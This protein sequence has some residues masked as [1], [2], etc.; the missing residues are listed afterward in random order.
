MLAMEAVGL[1]ASAFQRMA[2]GGAR[3][4]ST[5]HKRSATSYAFA[6]AYGVLLRLATVSN[7]VA[8]VIIT[9]A[10]IALAPLALLAALLVSPFL[11]IAYVGWRA[12]RSLMARWRLPAHPRHLWHAL[13]AGLPA[14][15]RRIARKP[16]GD[17]LTT[18]RRHLI[19]LI[20]KRRDVTLW[21]IPAA[22]WPEVVDLKAPFVLCVP[23]LVTRE[24]P[25]RFV[26][27]STAIEADTNETLKT[28]ERCTN[29]ITY[30]Q[31]VKSSIANYVDPEKST[32]R[33]IPNGPNELASQIRVMNAPLRSPAV[34]KFANQV[35][36]D[37]RNI[38]LQANPYLRTFDFDTIRYVFY[39]AQARPNKNFFTLIRAYRDLL[40]KSMLPHKLIVTADLRHLPDVWSY[41]TEQRLQYDVLM[42]QRVSDQVLAALYYK[43]ELAVCP[44]LYEGGFPFTFCEALSVGTPAVLAR[45]P[46]VL[47]TL[48]SQAELLA[49][50]TFD[51]YS[52]EDLHRRMVWALNNR[53][54][55]LRQQNELYDDLQQ[56]SWDVVSRE[57]LG[58][59]D[60]I[61]AK[62]HAKP[63]P[64][65]IWARS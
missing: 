30:S 39:A 49:T 41:I 2:R 24:L 15:F 38:Y 50:S 59:F 35:V 46:T 14:R 17:I 11:A 9:L 20:N 6:G 64:S 53:E 18:D 26:E 52:H 55:L 23:D 28:I 63:R 31:T 36:S 1:F 54:A 37:Y 27:L 44:S 57:Y 58:F 62:H 60:E 3:R 29:F 5:G 4:S 56:R 16:W 42:F 8:K 19:R 10:A 45:S 25:L 65:W 51:P 48:E 22:F 13:R 47:E 33:V 43:A 32:V 21:Y 34:D 7:P 61:I 12:R 40:R